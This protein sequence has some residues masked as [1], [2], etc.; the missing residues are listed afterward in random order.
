MAVTTYFVHVIYLFY[1]A[2]EEPSLIFLFLLFSCAAWKKR[3]GPR[4]R[5][6]H[7]KIG[8]PMSLRGS[9]IVSTGQN[10]LSNFNTVHPACHIIKTASV[11]CLSKFQKEGMLTKFN[12]GYYNWFK[13]SN[14]KT[15]KKIYCNIP[16]KLR[17]GRTAGEKVMN[18]NLLG[19]LPQLA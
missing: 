6:K 4:T 12:S 2:D 5:F 8:C 19:G 18:R 1:N 13:N 10:I 14:R 15:Q 7:C 16:L 11:I 17:A 3:A 9:E